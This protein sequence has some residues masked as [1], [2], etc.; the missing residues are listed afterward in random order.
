L[1]ERAFDFLLFSNCVVT[2]CLVLP[3]IAT[4]R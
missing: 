1:L 3:R 4:E 2:I